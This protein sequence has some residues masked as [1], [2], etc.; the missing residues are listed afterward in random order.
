M[1]A[2][3]Y[4]IGIA[5]V[6]LAL[7]APSPSGLQRRLAGASSAQPKRA[8]PPAGP[9]TPRSAVTSRQLKPPRP[10]DKP[11]KPPA[12]PAKKPPKKPRR[13]PS[14]F[15]PQTKGLLQQFLRAEMS[16][17]E[18]IVFAA[19][20]PGRDGH[21]YA[22]FGYY[23]CDER[24]KVY[25]TGGKLYKLN[26][27]S[28]KL[29]T[30]LADPQG[31]IRDPQVHY[32]AGKVLFSWRK[33]GT[34][35]YNLY[36]IGIDGDPKSLRRITSGPWDDIEPAYLPDGGIVFCS[37]RCNRWVN[38]WLTPVAV[39]YRCEANG[40]GVRMLSSNNEHDNTPW[41]MPDGRVLYTRWEYVD[42]SQVHYHHLWAMNP[43]GTGQ[44]VYFGN[45]HGGTTM[46]DA[47][48]IPG[49]DKVVACFSPGHGRRE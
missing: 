9:A 38:C 39:L 21:W 47:K 30:L 11:P 34:D 41:P 6:V 8:A 24:R 10:A 48:P 36:E 3:S 37:S 16:D 27:R 44:M 40:S 46:I 35:C 4:R 5:A 43:D 20:Q 42:R 1:A 18:E 12:K 28:G 14:P 13:R 17:V 33:G 7:V 32:D 29:T 25:G 15:P 22:N 2:G 49:T 45:L 26:L 31:G 19:R 23:A